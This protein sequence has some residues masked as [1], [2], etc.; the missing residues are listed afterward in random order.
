MIKT[1]IFVLTILKFVIS[2]KYNYT[3]LFNKAKNSNLNNPTNFQIP[4]MLVNWNLSFWLKVKFVNTTIAEKSIILEIN[5]NLNFPYYLEISPILEIQFNSVVLGNCFLDNN[6]TDLENLSANSSKWIFLSL[7][8][9]LKNFQLFYFEN[10]FNIV[11]SEEYLSDDSASFSFN[12]NKINLVF[13]EII[14]AHVHFF[15]F[16]IPV[17]D[18]VEIM[19]YP[20]KIL[21]LY[22][23]SNLHSNE[24]LIVNYANFKKYQN[25]KI[26]NFFKVPFNKLNSYVDVKIE[27]PFFNSSIVKNNLI[28]TFKGNLNFRNFIRSKTE[29]ENLYFTIRW[30][31]L[32]NE[33][34]NSSLS[35]QS[36][37]SY[38]SISSSNHQILLQTIL[39][40]NDLTPNFATDPNVGE[41]SQ[42]IGSQTRDDYKMEI[43]TI[44]RVKDIPLPNN[45][46]RFREFRGIISKLNFEGFLNFDFDLSFYNYYIFEIE[47]Y[48]SDNTIFYFVLNEVIVYTGDFIDDSVEGEVYLGKNKEILVSCLENKEL[49]RVYPDYNEK[50]ILD[51]CIENE[52]ICPSIDGCAFCIDEICEFCERN[53]VKVGNTCVECLANQIVFDNACHNTSELS[54]FSVFSIFGSLETDSSVVIRFEMNSLT[55]NLDNLSPIKKF[56]GMLYHHNF[57]FN[58]DVEFPM[59]ILSTIN[60]DNFYSKKTLY[61]IFNGIIDNKNFLISTG[62]KTTQNFDF[63]EIQN[64]TGI[65][66]TTCPDKMIS[67]KYCI[68]P[69]S[70]CQKEKTSKNRCF[71]CNPNYT[72][73]PFDSDVYYCLPKILETSLL[74]KTENQIIKK[75]TIPCNDQNCYL[76]SLNKIKCYKCQKNYT[77]IISLN[78]C[79]PNTSLITNCINYDQTQNQYCNNCSSG[80]FIYSNSPPYECIANNKKIN[81]CKIYTESPYYECSSC[82]EGYFLYVSVLGIVVCLENA[83]FVSNCD[84]YDLGSELCV[85]CESEFFVAVVDDRNG[86]ISDSFFIQNCGQYSDGNGFGCVDCETNFFLANILNEGSCVDEAFRV[87][88]CRSYSQGPGFAC[89]GCDLGFTLVSVLNFMT[90][91]GDGKLLLNCLDYNQGPDFK[92]NSCEVEFFLFL[93]QSSIISCIPDFK[94]ISN[95]FDYSPG[96]DFECINCNVGFFLSTI[97]EVI[98]CIDDFFYFEN[99]NDYNGAPEFKCNSCNQEYYFT[100]VDGEMFCLE[101]SLKTDNCVEYNSPEYECTNCEEDYI[102]ETNF[103][104]TICKKENIVIGC[105]NYDHHTNLCIDCEPDH[106][107]TEEIIN[108]KI[109]FRCIKNSKSVENCNSYSNQLDPD[110]IKCIQDYFLLIVYSENTN[111]KCVE[112]KFQIDQCKDYDLSEFSCLQCNL[113]NFLIGKVQPDDSDKNICLNKEKKINNCKDYD[114]IT[115]LC[116]EC[117]INYI[118]VNSSNNKKLCIENNSVISNCKIYSEDLGCL[119]YN[120][121]CSKENIEDCPICKFDE[122]LVND[123]CVD[124]CSK[125]ALN[126]DICKQTCPIYLCLKFVPFCLECERI[127]FRKCS[128]CDSNFVLNEGKCIEEKIMDL[129]LEKVECEE[130]CSNCFNRLCIKCLFGYHYEKE[131]GICVKDKVFI[132]KKFEDNDCLKKN[133]FCFKDGKKQFENCPKC[134]TKCQCEINYENKSLSFLKCK[135]DNVEF[136][137]N[138]SILI[139][140]KD[141]TINIQS[142]KQ[143]NFKFKSNKKEKTLIQ[144]SN[145][146]I[147]KTKNCSFDNFTFYEIKNQNFLK[148]KISKEMAPLV[149]SEYAIVP[150]LTSI[151]SNGLLAYLLVIFQMQEIFSYLF[152]IN[153]NGGEIF[154][155]INNANLEFYKFPSIIDNKNNF[156]KDFIFEREKYSFIHFLEFQDLTMIFIFFIKEIIFFIFVCFKTIYYYKKDEEIKYNEYFLKKNKYLKNR[157]IYFYHSFLLMLCLKYFPKSKKIFLFHN[158]FKNSFLEFGFIFFTFFFIFKTFHDLKKQF[159]FTRQNKNYEDIQYDNKFIILKKIKYRKDDIILNRL[160]I[161]NYI[162]FFFRSF[163]L[164]NY[165]E[166]LI[167]VRSLIFLSFLIFITYIIFQITKKNNIYLIFWIFL[168]NESIFLIYFFLGI[169][170]S[171]NYIP[172][173]LLN[174]LYILCYVGKFSESIVI[175]VFVYS[176]NKIRKKIKN[177]KMNLKTFVFEEGLKIR[178]DRSSTYCRRVKERK[179]KRRRDIKNGIVNTRKKSIS[180][181]KRITK[182]KRITRIKRSN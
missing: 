85:G 73:I 131:K 151:L 45:Q 9:N 169:L 68:T 23:L 34:K 35:F 54:V 39:T 16:L 48:Y 140:F 43:I 117:Q 116:I 64:F 106:E 88:N 5:N 164:Q 150:I 127:D 163:I 79:I 97:L 138:N 122:I 36:R 103:N 17:S 47:K 176:K 13:C 67:N 40:K 139:N 156:E 71:E 94:N 58:P 59:N 162:I 63:D 33:Q 75:T 170:Y 98:T 56:D 78:R 96:L 108:F 3:I 44:V 133:I 101:H 152:L 118:L 22:K 165:F 21:A 61:K 20:N 115:Q 174:F 86:C 50:I 92:C 29:F 167:I 32:K 109:T 76:C 112:D 1:Y 155:H 120:K 25:L 53:F 31:T 15:N 104:K 93:H 84:E 166:N 123:K 146:L 55:N 62:C 83:F 27:F 69:F 60:F 66:Q 158:L 12:N 171:R 135:N 153:F 57:M 134:R 178:L 4:N 159:D 8:Y 74:P 180:K 51:R 173:L 125:E 70:N 42:S 100:I 114:D 157:I 128:K 87:E 124:I 177:K 11:T 107:I 143:I 154:K 102:L 10:E 126:C 132:D 95:C 121:I 136:S 2:E 119:E 144:I 77:L 111:N 37:L 113:E 99:C 137:N 28:F 30:F 91:V 181:F 89:L 175:F 130:G 19:Y 38:S 7:N 80:F 6:L 90:C 148:I 18:L 182:I 110:C 65:C 160:M 26:T 149:N 82:D 24:N 14:F 105:K 41:F 129:I 81:F 147:F 72:P 52:F 161:Y 168:A 142:K 179:E 49:L 172:D 145:R 141:V 46:A